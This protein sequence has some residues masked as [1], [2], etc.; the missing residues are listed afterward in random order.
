MRGEEN[1]LVKKNSITLQGATDLIRICLKTEI[2]IDFPPPSEFHKEKLPF[3]DHNQTHRVGFGLES[4]CKQ[5]ST[6]C[7]HQRHP[8]N[9]AFA[10]KETWI[11][12]AST[13][14]NPSFSLFL[15]SNPWFHFQRTECNAYKFNTTSKSRVCFYWARSFTDTN[16]YRSL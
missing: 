10:N 11:V 13:S 15:L 16:Q 3:V 7:L 2:F 12:D 6:L 4:S 8:Y 14:A 1:R 5:K 9:A